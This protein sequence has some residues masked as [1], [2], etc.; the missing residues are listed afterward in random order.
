M[1]RTWVEN[2]G[3]GIQ[4]AVEK[5]IH[6]AKLSKQEATELERLVGRIARGTVFPKDSEY[7]SQY[8]LWEAKL[9]GDR[10]T[11][12]L[13]YAERGTGKLVLVGLLFTV[14]KSNRLPTSTFK[15]AKARL[16]VWDANNQ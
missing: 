8:G 7:L 10:R 5:E 6:K 4:E 12:R 9:Q 13:L 1:T 15:A 14:K 3:P 2:A 11:F 16:R